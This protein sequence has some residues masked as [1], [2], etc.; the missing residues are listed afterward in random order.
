MGAEFIDKKKSS[1]DF[2][3]GEYETAFIVLLKKDG[4]GV[5]GLAD[6]H[7]VCPDCKKKIVPYKVARNAT[8]DDMYRMCCELKSTLKMMKI[9]PNVTKNVM[10][11]LQNKEIM[12]NVIRQGM[13]SGKLII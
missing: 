4:G 6:H 10:S 8:F 12:R 7:S 11:A 5:I 9:V 2:R 1:E 3:A 13:Q